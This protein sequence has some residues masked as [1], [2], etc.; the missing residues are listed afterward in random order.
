MASVHAEMIVWIDKI[1]TDSRETV[2][3]AVA[4]IFREQRPLITFSMLRGKEFQLSQL[5]ILVA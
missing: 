2:S 5:C 3:V 1:G 4:T